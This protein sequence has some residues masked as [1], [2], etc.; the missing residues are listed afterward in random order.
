MVP[1]SLSVDLG[2]S[3]VEFALVIGIRFGGSDFDLT[4]PHEISE[5]SFYHRV[6][7]GEPTRL[8]ELF[9]RFMSFDLG[10][11]VD[12]YVKVAKVL[13]LYNMF[14]GYD[15]PHNIDS[16]IWSL[17]EDDDRFDSFPWEAYSYRVLMHYMTVIPKTAEGLASRKKKSYHFYG[18]IWV[19]QVWAYEAIRPLGELCGKVTSP[20]A[21]PRCLRWTFPRKAVSFGD[22]FKREVDCLVVLETNNS[23]IGMTHYLSTQ[24]AD[25]LVVQY[26]V[27]RNRVV[28]PTYQ[29]VAGESRSDRASNPSRPS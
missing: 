2:F 28:R 4:A 1:Q 22:I 27:T 29:A 11:R 3:P 7:G 9:A 13:V 16:W 25:V 19:L 23:E 17:V 8:G 20:L 6:L 18:L 24:S 12:D 21:V 5:D 15:Q 14:I 26:T 10:L